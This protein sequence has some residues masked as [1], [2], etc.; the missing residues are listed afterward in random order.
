MRVVKRMLLPGRQEAAA[1]HERRG[2][3]PKSDGHVAEMGSEGSRRD[4]NAGRSTDILT[5]THTVAS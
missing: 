4:E 1:G 5:G 2:R 3:L